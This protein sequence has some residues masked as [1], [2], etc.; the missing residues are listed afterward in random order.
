MDREKPKKTINVQLIDKNDKKLVKLNLNSTP[1]SASNNSFLPTTIGS[2]RSQITRMI[3]E[4]GN[5]PSNLS[6]SVLEND[7][8]LPSESDVST[9]MTVAMS[10]LLSN[11]RFVSLTKLEC[12]KCDRIF[13]TES[14][15]KHHLENDDCG[16]ENCLDE[17]E[18]QR[19]LAVEKNRRAPEQKSGLVINSLELAKLFPKCFI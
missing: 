7:D 10:S 9:G 2:L 4:D 5:K 1:S 8:D 17:N 19:F 13:T 12:I 3:N 14:L 18:L 6:T 11:D 16:D 15:Y